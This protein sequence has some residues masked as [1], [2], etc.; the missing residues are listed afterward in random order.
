M[1]LALLKDRIKKNQ[2][3]LKITT[4]LKIMS[5]TRLKHLKQQRDNLF[6]YI[7]DI[8]INILNKVNENKEI[9]L[10]EQESLESN[11]NIFYIN[12]FLFTDMSFCGTLNKQNE[13][14]IKD[15]KKKFDENKI[16]SHSLILGFKGEKYKNT[17]LNIDYICK[18]YDK[19]IN[20]YIYEEIHKII[21]KKVKN[22]S[23]EKIIINLYSCM[24]K[25]IEIHY[26]SKEINNEK[27]V[28]YMEFYSKYLLSS[29][30]I[31]YKYEEC[32]ARLMKVTTAIKNSEKLDHDLK[33]SFNKKRQEMITKDLLEVISGSQ[34][35]IVD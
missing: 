22:S 26:I 27:N 13:S 17:H 25:P 15:I 28:N 19:N 21:M 9:D 3:I 10:K 20:K 4:S 31:N 7:E 8:K 6:R 5:M 16:N 23:F 11:K 29:N 32:K 14:F 2:S 34:V 35:D 24:A 12:V 1:E 30:I 33:I 18:I